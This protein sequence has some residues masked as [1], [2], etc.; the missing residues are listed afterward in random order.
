MDSTFIGFYQNLCFFYYNLDE[1]YLKL[2][3]FEKNAK[4]IFL[5]E[6]Y[7]CSP[8]YFFKKRAIFKKWFIFFV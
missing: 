1:Y 7:E 6:N 3:I 4:E 8:H 5:D 2:L